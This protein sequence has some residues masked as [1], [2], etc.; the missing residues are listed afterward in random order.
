MSLSAFLLLAAFIYDANDKE[1]SGVVFLILAA[2]AA[3]IEFIG[4]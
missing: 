2:V 1:A 4:R 3:V